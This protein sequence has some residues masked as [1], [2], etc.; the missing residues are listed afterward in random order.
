MA[1]Y[2]SI[3]INVTALG[4]PGLCAVL[5]V[6]RERIAAAARG[7]AQ[8]CQSCN[9]DQD[10]FFIV[11]DYCPI[12]ICIYLSRNDPG[13]HN[14]A[15]LIWVVIRHRI[16]PCPVMKSMDQLRSLLVM[17]RYAGVE[18]VNHMRNSSRL[19]GR[20]ATDIKMMNLSAKEHAE[21]LSRVT[22]WP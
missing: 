3:L 10:P 6:E 7:T 19:E 22:R 15:C 20:P 1:Y 5:R 18:V 4:T 9:L 13:S 11:V 12:S 8:Q 21:G 2:T 16:K 17:G 14:T